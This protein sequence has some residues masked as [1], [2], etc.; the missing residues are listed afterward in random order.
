MLDNVDPSLNP[1]VV[2]DSPLSAARQD[3]N[4]LDDSQK[5]T[6]SQLE[7]DS[8]H[9]ADRGVE[10][11]GPLKSHSR[12]QTES[13]TSSTRYNH[14]LRSAGL[15][16]GFGDV[17]VTRPHLMR[18]V[19]TGVFT[20]IE[21]A[22]GD[23]E[24]NTELTQVEP[25]SEEKMVIVHEV[26]RTDS[27]A[28]VALKYGIALS[29]LRRAN[30]L[31]AS[32]SIHLRKV[33]YI[34]IDMTSKQ[35]DLVTASNGVQISHRDAVNDLPMSSSIRK[36]P[37]SE[38][39]F[40]PPSST[41]NLSSAQETLV[42]CSP[43]PLPKPQHTRYATTPSGSSLNTILQALPIAASTRDTIIARLS[44][45]STS[46]SY[47]DRERDW[48]RSDP[49][50]DE[51]HELDHVRFKPSHKPRSM[52]EDGLSINLV[53]ETGHTSRRDND[54][55]TGSS[56]KGRNQATWGYRSNMTPKTYDLGSK[57][58]TS[59]YTS[60]VDIS[61]VPLSVRTVQMEP[62]PIMEVPT[63]RNTD[64]NTVGSRSLSMRRSSN[65]TVQPEIAQIGKGK[66][67][68]EPKLIDVDFGPSTDGGSESSER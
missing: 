39:S 56:S 26:T 27:L 14:P 33:L 1:F 9:W 50:D 3:S 52:S 55:G 51:S 41:S 25:A 10:F 24:G 21:P 38:L 28:G 64:R 2:H 65:S 67:K 46:S 45:D 40:F 36:V 7:F 22:N 44:I 35:K 13:N 15:T 37:A 30:H 63:R 20:D 58:S 47:S 17:G 29:D 4:S 48:Q 43:Q 53:P 18:A 32:D 16:D 62:S 5:G 6:Q 66:E 61:P 42:D 12:A 68:I 54:Q 57:V 19:D 11:L 8:N 23:G 31:W 34:P 60:P 49:I 59:R